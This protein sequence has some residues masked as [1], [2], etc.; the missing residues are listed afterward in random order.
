MAS[1]DHEMAE[2]FQEAAPAPMEQETI[3]VPKDAGLSTEL[4]MSGSNDHE[5]ADYIPDAP[6]IA[7]TA[8]PIA[9]KQPTEVPKN[10]GVS[11]DSGTSRSS[12]Q[13]DES[14]LQ[15]LNVSDGPE[16]LR[17]QSRTLL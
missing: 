16:K 1:T 11:T 10:A 8:T 4:R 14:A 6:T 2:S 9:Q 12:D 17:R 3:E 15:H 7:P 5:M 13:A